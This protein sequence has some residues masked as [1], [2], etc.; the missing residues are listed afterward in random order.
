MVAE[1]TITTLYV[2]RNYRQYLSLNLVITPQNFM[3]GKTEKKHSS[4]DKDYFR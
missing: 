1:P 4:V 3:T 2:S